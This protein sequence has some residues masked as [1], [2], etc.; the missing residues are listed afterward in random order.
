VTRAARSIG[1][2]I[3]GLVMGALVLVA[4]VAGTAL[5]A[6]VLERIFALVLVALV[7]ETLWISSKGS[8]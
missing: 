8:K 3:A 6:Y 5:A 2:G 4:I 1:R 7:V